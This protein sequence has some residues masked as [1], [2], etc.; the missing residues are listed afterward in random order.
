MHKIRLAIFLGI[1]WCAITPVHASEDAATE[2]QETCD[3]DEPCPSEEEE[4]LERGFDP[5][6]VNA[7]LPACT[8]Q[9]EGGDPGATELRTSE[10]E[11]TEDSG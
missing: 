7:S 8:P 5:C 10:A 2:A 9:E 1:I 11:D 4:E 6:L 3:S